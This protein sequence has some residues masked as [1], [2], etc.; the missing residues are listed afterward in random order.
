MSKQ[1]F[2]TEYYRNNN[3][4]IVWEI[5]FQEPKTEKLF[6]EKSFSLK[7]KATNTVFEYKKLEK[8]LNN[9]ITTERSTSSTRTT[10]TTT[11]TSTTTTTTKTTTTSISTGTTI[12]FVYYFL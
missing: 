3:D 1:I 6:Q 12:L 5:A 10:T 8:N 11:T 4:T 2:S 7:N 9:R